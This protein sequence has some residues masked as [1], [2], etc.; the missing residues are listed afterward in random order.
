[1][2]SFIQVI[3]FQKNIKMGHLSLS[4][5]LGIERHYLRKDFLLHLFLLKMVKQLGSGKFL[6][7]D[8]QEQRMAQ[9]LPAR[10]VRRLDLVV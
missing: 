8:L 9:K 3:N 10:A 5:A 2:Y 1:V 6:R 4:M 7:M